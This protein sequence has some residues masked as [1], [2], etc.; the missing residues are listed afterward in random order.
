MSSYFFLQ[1]GL[2]N[3]F[4][5]EVKNYSEVH[6]KQIYIINQPLGDSKY[7][8][9][10]QKAF[11]ILCPKQKIT[12]IDLGNS[13]DEFE[14]F[15][16]D[17]LEDLG[18]ISDKYQYK[19]QIGRPRKWIK[20]LIYSVDK[21]PKDLD[22]FFKQ[23]IINNSEDQKLAELLITLLTGSINDIKRVGVKV[24]NTLLEKVKQRILL[25]EGVKLYY[26]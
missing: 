22:R 8:Y 17:F 14:E 12:F 1:P 16:L 19:D 9:E 2:N 7:K 24:P 4:F 5:E 25:F 3:V 6:K 18:S 20:D 11:V 23:T 21:A 13:K 15:K 26:F 10:Y